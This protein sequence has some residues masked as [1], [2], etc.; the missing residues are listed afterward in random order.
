[1]ILYVTTT[2]FHLQFFFYLKKAV[3]VALSVSKEIVPVDSWQTIYE[4][5]FLHPHQHGISSDSFLIWQSVGSGVGKHFL[6]IAKWW[7]FSALWGH[8]ASVA[9]NQLYLW[10]AEAAGD[11]TYTIYT[12]EH[13]LAQENFTYKIQ[14]W[15]PVSPGALGY[16]LSW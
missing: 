12:W 10:S 14:W 7:T 5:T 13:Y 2:Y 15:A 4:G 3:H 16:W 9:T 11:D 8:E 6:Q 1:M